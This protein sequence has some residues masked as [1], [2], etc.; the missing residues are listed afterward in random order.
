MKDTKLGASNN[1]PKANGNAYL[2]CAPLPHYTIACCL[3]QT[4]AKTINETWFCTTKLIEVFDNSEQNTVY[5]VR[6]SQHHINLLFKNYRD[7]SLP[8]RF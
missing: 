5:R 8:E 2:N 6:T 7:F 1:T 4:S 3:A